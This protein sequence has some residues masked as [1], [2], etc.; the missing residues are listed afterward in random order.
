MSND[1]IRFVSE[2]VCTHILN[3]C[4]TLNGNC[5]SGNCYSESK[6]GGRCV[7]KDAKDAL[8]VLNCR[9]LIRSETVYNDFL[10][11]EKRTIKPIRANLN[12]TH[13]IVLKMICSMDKQEE[14]I[15]R[16]YQCKDCLNTKSPLEKALYRKFPK[17]I[18]NKC[19]HK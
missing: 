17:M 18:S 9:D 16:A 5:Y 15:K 4:E 3:E 7:C 2:G 14:I 1:M 11:E 6:C 13:E 10:R 12:K 8:V 19:N